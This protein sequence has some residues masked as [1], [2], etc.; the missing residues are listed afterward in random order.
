[1]KT[2]NTHNRALEL[3]EEGFKSDAQR[4]A[5]FAKRGQVAKGAHAAG[6]KAPSAAAS[7]LKKYP[8]NFKTGGVSVKVD[9]KGLTFQSKGKTLWAP[10]EEAEY[11]AGRFGVKI[12]DPYGYKKSYKIS[13]GK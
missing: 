10:Y 8:L 2:T 6:S 4:K 5:V 3:I 7:H 12:G 9:S 13:R 1:M 11:M